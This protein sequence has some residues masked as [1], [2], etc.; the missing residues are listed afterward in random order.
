MNIFVLGKSLY[1]YSFLFGSSTKTFLN[2]QK[3]MAGV[4][5]RAIVCSYA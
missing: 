1:K 3:T 4:R 5:S 2:Y